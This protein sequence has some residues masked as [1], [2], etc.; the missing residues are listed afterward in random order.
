M[1]KSIAG[2]PRNILGDSTND[3]SN[4]LH[5]CLAGEEEAYLRVY[6]LYAKTIFRLCYGILQNREDAEEVLQDTFDYAFRKLHRF[7]KRKA[8][9]KTWLYR[10]AISRCR[11]KRRRKLL[12]TTSLSQLFSGESVDRSTP[13]PSE[14]VAFNEVQSVIWKALNYLSP[15]LKE[16]AVLRYYEGL[17]Y[18][19][20]S[21][22]LSIPQ[23]TAES[24]MRLAHQALKQYLK[25]ILERTDEP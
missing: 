20:I 13:D 5:K 19:E 16:T 2:S 25:P 24:R 22:V 23:K 21:D 11:N 17:T 4:Y 3:I 9:F 18:R 14:V 12:N 15:K 7:D 10:I 8:S 1:S 6:N